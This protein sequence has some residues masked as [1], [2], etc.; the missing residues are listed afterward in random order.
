[1]LIP[2]NALMSLTYTPT[3]S[4][5]YRVSLNSLL[6]PNHL[7]ILIRISPGRCWTYFPPGI[8]ECSILFMEWREF[9]RMSWTIS[10]LST[11]KRKCNN[12]VLL[13]FG[14]LWDERLWFLFR[15]V[16]WCLYMQKKEK[17]G[18]QFSR[19]FWSKWCWA[20]C[21]RALEAS[22]VESSMRSNFISS[23]H[24]S[25]CSRWILE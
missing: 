2:C 16:L 9:T 25:M 8:T 10:K 23:C 5:W 11:G 24:F 4:N 20:F 12:I 14:S 22:F 13:V 19:T 6:P 15:L 21:R 1:M 3:T 7:T 17:K 18:S